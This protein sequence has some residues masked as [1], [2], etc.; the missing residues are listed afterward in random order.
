MIDWKKI[1]PA[2]VYFG[3]LLSAM[4]VL[5]L[6]PSK[7]MWVAHIVMVLLPICMIAYIRFGGLLN[8]YAKQYALLTVLW[9]FYI[10]SREYLNGR[11]LDYHMIKYG[12]LGLAVFFVVH[13][14]LKRVK[15][16]DEELLIFLFILPAGVHFAYMWVDI[17]LYITRIG[18]SDF[19]LSA[20]KDVPRIGRRYLSNALVGG[21]V[22][23]VF[24][25]LMLQRQKKLWR[26]LAISFLLSLLVLDARGAYVS[27]IVAVLILALIAE[28]A[29][30]MQAVQKITRYRAS[31]IVIIVVVL[32]IGYVSGSDRW[33]NFSRSIENAWLDTVHKAEPYPPYIDKNFWADV[34]DVEKCLTERQ[35]RCWIEQSAYLRFAWMIEGVLSLSKVPF[36]V[37]GGD[38]YMGRYWGVEGDSNKWQRVDSGMTEYLVTFG[39]VSVVYLCLLF[40]LFFNSICK[41]QNVSKS[42]I[43]IGLLIV[44]LAGRMAFDLVTEG[45]WLYLSAL[46]AAYFYLIDKG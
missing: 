15:I 45:L 6:A 32:S 42:T 18:A 37:G 20:L 7:E 24:L 12:A 26:Y 5:M 8:E 43:A 23:A 33:M 31:L 25:S 11:S 44:V 3:G 19:V 34:E 17:Y 28:R 39:I 22:G 46:F 36:G 29:M 9:L 1:D 4:V 10:S 41:F 40:N 16:S 35:K 27:L 21:F 13:V 30:V 2:S 14:V 38:N